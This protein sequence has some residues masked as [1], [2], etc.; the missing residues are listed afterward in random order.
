MNVHWRQEWPQDDLSAAAR[1]LLSRQS[2]T[3]VLK[4]LSDDFSVRLL[5]SGVGQAGGFWA[6]LAQPQQG[7]TREVLL[8]L[9]GKPVIWARS[10]CA[11]NSL[12]WRGLLDCGTQPLGE[13]LFDGSLGVTRTPIEYAAGVPL[14]VDDAAERYFQTAFAAR[15]SVFVHGN[16]ETLGLVEC[17]L[18]ALKQYL[19]E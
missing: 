7:F 2:L 12:F 11:E 8:C 19:P 1:E 10:L 18:P 5:H 4:S 16:G 17:F 3:V 9:D 15:R 14:G 6:G 13:R